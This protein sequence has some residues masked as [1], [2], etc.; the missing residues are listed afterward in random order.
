MEFAGNQL[1]FKTIIATLSVAFFIGRIHLFGNT[2]P[3]AIAFITVMLSVSRLYIY[4]VPI[5][6]A[7][8]LTYSGSGI[9]FYGDIGALIICSC[10]FFLL[11]KQK[12]TINKKTILA[13]ISVVAGNCIYYICSDISYLF[14]IR[15]IISECI[16]LFVYIRVFDTIVKAC[17]TAD[18]KIYETKEK[19]GPAFCIAVLSLI[20][21]VDNIYVVMTLWIL[22]FLVVQYFKGLYYGM[23]YTCVAMVFWQCQDIS[24][25]SVFMGIIMGLV[26]GWF[27]GYTIEERYQKL[28]MGIVFF[29]IAQSLAGIFI[30]PIAIA[31]SIFIAIPTEIFRKFQYHIK[32][33]AIK[34]D[35][36]ENQLKLQLVHN[37]LEE[38]RNLFYSLSDTYFAGDKEKEI[39]AQQF[40][41]LGQTVDAMLREIFNL[42]QNPGKES[43][44][45]VPV[46]VSTH[47]AG[48]VSGDS[49]MAFRYSTH[50]QAMIISDGMGHGEKASM[51]SR[52]V[53]STLSKLLMAGFDVDIA[54]KTINSILMNGKSGEMF[55]TVDLA[56]INN[57][58]NHIKLFKM[59]AASTF[60]KR[61][62]QVTTV[63][64]PAPPVGIVD[65][66]KISY[67]D[68]KLRKGD[69]LI[70]VSDGITDCI[71]ED[72]ENIMLRNKIS[73]INSHN[74]ET[75]ADIVTEWAVNKY[76]N[77]EKDDL[78]VMVASF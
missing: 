43:I 58:N 68:L 21:T 42:Q 24:S 33:T 54:V 22:T 69:S 72:S 29:I 9:D 28:I 34:D 36:E 12:L 56:L 44:E 45:T 6:L 55:A 59:G 23:L 39:I 3:A 31:T 27:A 11:R 46:G 47:A 32:K 41:G 77:K 48:R 67:L 2:F 64:S 76:E 35:R 20:G 30:Y 4:S 26:I 70:M 18:N 10:S 14:S 63:Q 60:I 7:G 65:G 17:C 49:C 16:A 61:G 75:I 5:L 74:P 19:T 37:M 73:E 40:K 25:I 50:Y 53:V 71:R 52:M 78:T 8:M 66:W 13:I 51:E 57:A 1:N 15:H 62:N 38:K